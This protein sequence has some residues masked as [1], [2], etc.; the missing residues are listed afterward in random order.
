MKY[1][2]SKIILLLLPLF[3]IVSCNEKLR[4]N[5]YIIDAESSLPIKDASIIINN[6]SI[7]S[8]ASG[9]FKTQSLKTG[10]E[11]LVK[12]QHP[13]Y[14]SIARF[15]TPEIVDSSGTISFPLLKR[16]EARQFNTSD[17]IIVDFFDGK[18]KIKIDPSNWHTIPRNNLEKG[19][20]FEGEF[21]LQVTYF[22]PE[23]PAQISAS[24]APL[25]MESK[26]GRVPLKSYGMLEIFA[27]DLNGNQLDISENDVVEIELPS[28]IDINQNTG[29]FTVSSTGVWEYINE[30]T[31]N[32]ESN[33]LLGSVSSISDAWNADDPCAEALVCVR[34][35]FLNTDGSPASTTFYYRGLTYQTNWEIGNS[36]SQGIAE[37]YVCPDQVFQIFSQIPC[38]GGLSASDPGYD[39]C[40]IQNGISVIQTIDLSNVTLTPPCTDL[41]IIQL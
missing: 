14:V 37:I 17:S 34:I 23:N 1:M 2:F 33:T 19:V 40:C 39:F 36:D 15:Y 41:G 21:R 7:L 16:N 24:P 5:G 25:L 9:S 22:N 31:F 35:K 30:F 29:M 38:C 11:Y 32:A 28:I 18:G 8:D 4:L 3:L 20:P 13:Q 26:N 27:T 10:M 6:K 12:V